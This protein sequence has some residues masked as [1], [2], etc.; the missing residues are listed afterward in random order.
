MTGQRNRNDR[1]RERRL[2]AI[3]E[4]VVSLDEAACAETCRRAIDEGLDAM[5]IVF[6]GLAAG[7][8]AV[9]GLYARREYFI[10]EMLL[11]SDAFAAG[12]DVVG[13]YLEHRTKATKGGRRLLTA[14]TAVRYGADG[15]A[16]DAFAA[17][18]EAARL[19]ENDGDSTLPLL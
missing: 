13:P 4:A 11:S 10:P 14:E 19:L 3:R 7:M 1:D 6:R 17:A 16:V 12:L 8:E 15:Y 9:K 2:A 18:E 5:E